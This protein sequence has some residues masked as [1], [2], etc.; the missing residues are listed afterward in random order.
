MLKLKRL[1]LLAVISEIAFSEFGVKYEI[2]L[3]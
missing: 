2:K 3:I 1:W